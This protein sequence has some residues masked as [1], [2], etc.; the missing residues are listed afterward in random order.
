[1]FLYLHSKERAAPSLFT[2]SP[3]VSCGSFLVSYARGCGFDIQCLV[4]VSLFQAQE[5]VGLI[6][7]PSFLVQEVVGFILISSSLV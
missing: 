4:L 6:L 2:C 1:M 5:V 7:I 3:P